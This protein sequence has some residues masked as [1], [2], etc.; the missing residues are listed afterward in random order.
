MGNPLKTPISISELLNGGTEFSLD[1]DFQN[2]ATGDD[3]FLDDDYGS[4]GDEEERYKEMLAPWDRSFEELRATMVPVSDMIYKRIARRG[5]GEPI[6]GNVTVTIDY[7][8]FFENE[9][10]PFDSTTLRSAPYK[11]TVGKCP[12][13]PGLEQAVQTMCV[14]EEA[15]FLIAYQLL[16]GELGC[17][18]RIPAK[19]DG[20]FVIK[21]ISCVDAGDA[22]ALAKLDEEE[23]RTYAVVKEKVAQ[24]R[25]YA[26]NSFQRNMITSATHKYLEAV[27]TLKSC[28][29]KD[30]QEEK[31]Q[32]ETLVALYT[33]L[34]VCFNRRDMPKDACR[35]V[36]EL[37]PL[38]DVQ[39]MAKV[40]YQEGR[41]LHKLGEHDRA[42]KCLL[43]AQKLEP[44]DENIGK[45]LK[46]LHESIEKH[47]KEMRNIWTR[48]FGMA[49]TKKKGMTAEEQS[50]AKSVKQAMRAFLDDEKCTMM[51]LPEGLSDGEVG[52][53]EELAKEFDIKLRLYV[54][55]NRKH[56]KFQKKS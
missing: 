6:T 17:Q 27:D 22:D 55:N 26:K 13:L 30:E 25:T 2:D 45:E 38:C 44:R 20:L 47:R 23:R 7:N 51:S 46:S 41:A 29:M 39:K 9:K 15:Q 11:F 18:P 4:S 36:N 16:F 52:V 54:D 49:D 43:R 32:R 56:Y 5:V 10:K 24:I 42:R 21:L 48:A 53:L 33:S 19:A 14:G 12:V 40:L 1:A 50:F 31:E 28:H 35:M 37:R 8:A 3:L 34:A